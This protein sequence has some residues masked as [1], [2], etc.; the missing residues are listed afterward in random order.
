MIRPSALLIYDG[1][2]AYCRG[3]ARLLRLLDRKGRL[4]QLPFEADEAQKLL[5]AQFD[6]D[7]GFAMYLAEPVRIHWGARAAERAT[8]RLSAPAWIGRLA[9]RSYP[10][11]VSIVSR[12]TR[13]ERTVC[14]P[15]CAMGTA[16]AARSHGEADLTDDARVL[17]GALT[18]TDAHAT[19]SG[20]SRA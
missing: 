15:G 20:Q 11:L 19:S 5:R 14:G 9:F 2:C 10:T 7:I 3:F 13:R 17:F 18:Q 12:L 8:A 4:L 1:E 6:A 16:T